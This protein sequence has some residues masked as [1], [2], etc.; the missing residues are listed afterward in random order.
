[1]H[2]AGFFII[3]FLALFLLFYFLWINGHLILNRKRALLFVGSFRRKDNCELT[4]S[5]CTGSVKKVIKLEAG[6]RY[7]FCLDH[8][9][10]KGEVSAAVENKKKETLLRLTPLQ[11]TGRLD[12]EPGERY[13]L[14]LRFERADGSLVLTWH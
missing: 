14:L 13:Y 7:L 5:S 8:T 1:M 9:L 11:K 12:V 6:R 3:L 2:Q 4:F 10:T